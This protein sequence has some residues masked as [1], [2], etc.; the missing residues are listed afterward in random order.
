MEH[1]ESLFLTLD[2][3]Q[4]YSS[5]AEAKVQDVMLSSCHSV[6]YNSEVITYQG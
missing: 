5:Q 3:N 4:K 6:S 2:D 1:S